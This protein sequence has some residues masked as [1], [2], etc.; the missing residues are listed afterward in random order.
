VHL[1]EWIEKSKLDVRTI[2]PVHGVAAT[3][4]DLRKSVARRTARP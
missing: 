4:D 1:L 3:M 2:V